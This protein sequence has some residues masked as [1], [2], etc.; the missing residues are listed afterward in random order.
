M[1]PPNLSLLFIMACFWLTYWVVLRFLIKPVGAVADERRRRVESAESTWAA[2]H[3]EYLSATARLEGELEE[4]ARAAGAA[5]AELRR[6]AQQRRQERLDAARQEV[7]QR[8]GAALAELGEQEEA[9]RREL[10]EQAR[11]LATE[12]ASRLLERRV[13]S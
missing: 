2:K 6:E 5:R 8:L 4:A 10:A 11:A 3:Q 1:N 13:A 9:A 7:D 12:L